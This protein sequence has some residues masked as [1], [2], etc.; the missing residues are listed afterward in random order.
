ELDGM[1]AAIIRAWPA[2]QVIECSN[3]GMDVGPFVEAAR[4]MQGQTYDLVLKL[5]SKKSLAASGDVNGATWRRDLM[6][7]L[8]GTPS[9]VDRLRPI[10]SGHEELGMIGATG[11]LLDRS[12]NGI[13][14][15]RDVNAPNM[16][17]L[18]DRLRVAARTQRFFRG[19]VFWARAAEILPP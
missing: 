16:N 6:T 4:L 2:A 17:L 7:G 3:R 8:V 12:S 9:V 10:F 5:H 11:M 1:R 18:G 14:N 19:T 13:A 15:G